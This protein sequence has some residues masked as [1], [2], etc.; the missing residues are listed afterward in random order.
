MLHNYFLGFFMILGV[1]DLAYGL[2]EGDQISV[3][4]GGL[5]VFITVSMLRKRTREEKGK[6]S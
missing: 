2:I 3:L 4:I 6:R 1:A 5:L